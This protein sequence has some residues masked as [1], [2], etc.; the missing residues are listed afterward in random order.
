MSLAKIEQVYRSYGGCDPVAARMVV[1]AACN[2]ECLPD[3][4]ATGKTQPSCVARV[5]QS[6]IGQSST[7]SPLE[8]ELTI[9]SFENDTS[10]VGRSSSQ[11]MVCGLKLV[12]K[13]YHGS[14]AQKARLCA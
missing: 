14:F 7:E 5:V 12:G 9:L 1:D 13:L 6:L 8:R 3:T 10:G 4:T 2:A 11:D